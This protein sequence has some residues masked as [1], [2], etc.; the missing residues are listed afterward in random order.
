MLIAR[1]I[2]QIFESNF[3]CMFLEVRIKYFWSKLLFQKQAKRMV[4]FYLPWEL[5]TVQNSEYLF[6]LKM[7]VA[8]FSLQRDILIY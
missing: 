1:S 5:K 4:N 3:C 6:S 7:Y 8:S 2:F